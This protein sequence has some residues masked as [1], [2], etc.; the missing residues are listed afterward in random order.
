MQQLQVPRPSTVGIILAASYISGLTDLGELPDSVLQLMALPERVTKVQA[1]NQVMFHE[2]G[3]NMNS[4]LRN[5]T[6][7]YQWVG[8]CACAVVKNPHW[9]LA[10]NKPRTYQIIGSVEPPSDLYPT[11]RYM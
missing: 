2:A 9:Y 4:A 3:K 7:T 6:S 11:I 10:G 1:D 5:D 8:K